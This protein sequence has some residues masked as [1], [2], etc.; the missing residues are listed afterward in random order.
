[1]D[2][3]TPG[4]FALLAAAAL[5][6]GFSKTSVSGANTISLAVFAAVLPA[7]ESTGVLLP[8]LIVGDICAVLVYRRHAHWPTLWRLFPAVAAGVLAGTAFLAFADDGAVRTSIGAILL[9]MSAMTYWRRRR[10]ARAPAGT[11]GEP[12]ADAEPGT[13][14]GGRLRARGYGVLGGFTTMVANAGGP[15][16]SLYL[17]SAGFR[18]LGFLGTSAWFFLIVNTSK[19][20]FSVGLGLIDG[21]SLLLD[22]VLVL[23]VVPGALLGRALAH[24]I[25]Q[26][27]FDQLVLAATVVGGVQLLLLS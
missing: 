8:L 5:L 11:D 25:N 20:P 6:V 12:G 13:G 18:K 9:A 1:M 10:A 26:A 7:K 22:A 17:L 27:L 21:S 19:V 23:F 15:V 4:A 2:T 24:R 14:R 3:I 16:M